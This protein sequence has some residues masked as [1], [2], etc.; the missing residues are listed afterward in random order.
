[1]PFGH[2]GGPQGNIEQLDAPEFTLFV[3]VKVYAV[4]NFL[5]AAYFRRAQLEIKSIGLV[6]SLILYIP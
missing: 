3:E 4:A 5:G 2:L 6:F 1:M